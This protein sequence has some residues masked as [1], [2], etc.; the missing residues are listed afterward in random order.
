MTTKSKYLRTIEDVPLIP[1]NEL[2]RSRLIRGESAL[3]SFLE[4]PPGARFPLHKHDCEQIMIMLEGTEDHVCG[5]EN[6][7]IRPGDVVIH[8]ANVE[9]GGETSTGYK[10]IDIFVPPREDYVE[11]MQK[12]GL[13]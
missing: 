7:V 6:F 12:H 9:H 10:A 2:T 11:L 4:Q 5:D 1:L 3:L 8:P 13:V